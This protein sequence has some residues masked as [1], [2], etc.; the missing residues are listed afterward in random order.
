MESLT[1]DIPWPPTANHIWQHA[2]GVNYLSK[3]YKEFLSV[4]CLV[5]RQQLPVKFRRL[6]SPVRVEID[7]YPPTRQRMDID[8][9]VKPILDALTRAGVWQDDSQVIEL[10]VR[11]C[12]TLKHGRAIIDI[13]ETE[14]R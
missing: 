3:R 10:R 11:K 12:P 2:R 7:L 5:V 4:T 14:V 1:L 6:E 8:N 9:R 13:Q